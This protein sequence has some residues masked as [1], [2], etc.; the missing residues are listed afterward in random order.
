MLRARQYAGA[1]G[2]ELTGLLSLADQGLGDGQTYPGPG[3]GGTIHA[4]MAYGTLKESPELD[5]RPAPQTVRA[6]VVA[7]FTLRPPGPHLTLCQSGGS[8]VGPQW[9]GRLA[10]DLPPAAQ[11]WGVQL[12]RRPSI[13]DGRGRAECATVRPSRVR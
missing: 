9:P 12:H 4:A 13:S 5:L 10:A 3:T 8:G 1:P 7:R 11:P 2:S 6:T